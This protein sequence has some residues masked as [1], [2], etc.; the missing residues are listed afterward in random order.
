[1]PIYEP[2][3]GAG[4]TN[5]AAGRPTLTVGNISHHGGIGTGSGFISEPAPSIAPLSLSRMV[6]LG[7]ADS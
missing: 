4:H 2:A 3:G 7:L 5:V 6:R 1:M